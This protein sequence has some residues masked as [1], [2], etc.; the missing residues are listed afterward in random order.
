MLSRCIQNISVYTHTP[1]LPTALVRETSS[2]L[3]SSPGTDVW[4]K[5]WDLETECS[6]L[7]GT[8]ILNSPHH[9]K[10]QGVSWKRIGKNAVKNCF[11]H[12]K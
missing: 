8:S 11:V 10:A 1:E 5:C 2:A 3:Y 4:S 12:M 6:S 7:N 9:I